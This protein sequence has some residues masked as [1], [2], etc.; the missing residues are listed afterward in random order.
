[1]ADPLKEIPGELESP[2]FRPTFASVTMDESGKVLL[3]TLRGP[4]R[5]PATEKR[6]AR[7]ASTVGTRQFRKEDL[8]V[9]TALPN[10]VRT[11]VAKAE[12]E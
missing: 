11:L 10:V 9:P 12:A 3:V 1:M 8:G 6:P 2:W 4:H 5:L 7:D